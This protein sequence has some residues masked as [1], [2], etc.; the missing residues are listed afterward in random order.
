MGWFKF[1]L[2]NYKEFKINELE[3]EL[4]EYKLSKE[5]ITVLKN[6]NLLP[7]NNLFNKKIAYV[8]IG[9]SGNI[10]YNSLNRYMPI[11]K[12]NFNDFTDYEKLL[13]ELEKYDVIISAIHEVQE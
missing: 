4:L 3:H 8:H 6:D 12:Y 5:A 2:N 11:D 10:F 13:E 1:D 7:L 9:T